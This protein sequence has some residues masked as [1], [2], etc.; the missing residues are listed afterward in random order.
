MAVEQKLIAG[1]GAQKSPDRWGDYSSISVDPTDDCT[2]WFTTQYLAGSGS[3]NWHTAIA[4]IKFNN[5]Q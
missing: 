5:C 4:R 2:F 1:K 3:F